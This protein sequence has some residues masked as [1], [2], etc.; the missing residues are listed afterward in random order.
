VIS[1]IEVKFYDFHGLKVSQGKVHTINRRGGILNYLSTAYLLSNS[2]TNNYWNQTTI[3]EFIV[4]GWVVSVFETRCRCGLLLPTEYR[5]LSVG[6]SVC[7][8]VTLVSPAKTAEPIEMPFGLWT[9]MGPRN[10]A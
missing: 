6:R 1:A 9:Q 8:S 10:D 5:G 7:R 4:G 2:C 3:V